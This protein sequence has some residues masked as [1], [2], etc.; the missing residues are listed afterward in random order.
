MSR[1][2]KLLAGLRVEPGSPPRLD[3][4]DPGA[5]LDADSKEAGLA[6]L[7]ELVE[8]LSLLHN[9]LAAEA[10]RALL[11]VLQGM[12]AS[13]KDGTIRHVLTGVNPQGCRVVSFKEP[14][15]AELAHDYLWRIHLACPVRGEIAIFNRSHYE[16]VVAVRVRELL[17]ESRWRP[18]YHQIRQFERTLSEE[19]TTVVKVFLHVSPA[20]Q[21]RRLQQRLDDPEKRWKFQ[22]GDLEDRRHFADFEAAYEEAIEETSTEAAPWYVVPADHNWVRNLAVAEILVATLE[23]LDP[24]LPAAAPGLDELRI[25]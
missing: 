5:R 22:L 16:D 24:K 7:D 12:D 18:R 19:G 9:R 4:R 1:T 2:H 17:P 14:S 21:R 20:E 11:L 10:Q 6:R 15:A 8:R 25:K 23:Q 13:G 3:R